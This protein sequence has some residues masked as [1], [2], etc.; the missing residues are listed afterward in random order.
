[1]MPTLLVV[2]DD[3]AHRRTLRVGLGARGYEVVEADDG[4][5][6]RAAVDARPPDLV[7][8]DLGLPDIDGVDLCRHLRLWPAVP[9]IVV[10]AETD[11]RRMVEAFA[12]GADDYVVKPV[13]I[14]VLAAR[15]AVH[16]RYA[17]QLALA[18]EP[19]VITIAALT[20]DLT[21]HVV[22]VGGR[23]VDLRPQQFTMLE[24]LARNAGRLVTHET[25]SRA[26]AKSTGEPDRKAIRV[27]VHRL[28]VAIGEGPDIPRIETELHVGYRLTS[29]A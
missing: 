16:L 25:L 9:I 11:D 23:I 14:D 4:R 15:I 3:G 7:L 26:L 5:S 21:A 28:R 17:E 13:V 29:P 12:V 22:A 20:V 6:A 19:E 1:M 2:D 24:V 10:S 27:A 18:A 8:L